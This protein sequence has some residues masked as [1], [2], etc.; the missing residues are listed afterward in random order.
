MQC[1]TV[2]KGSQCTFMAKKGC[3]FNG[4]SCNPAVEACAGC[5]K[6]VEFNGGLYC[7]IAPDPAAKW[8]LGSCNFA[9]H[10]ERGQIQEDARK[11]NPLKASKR[12]AATK[13]KAKKK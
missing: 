2:R 8:R 10:I 7:S 13:T 6:V 12:A 4:G 1:E 5:N 11:L 3:S 9:T